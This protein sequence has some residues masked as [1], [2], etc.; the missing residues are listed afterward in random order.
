MLLVV[1]H[2]LM[3]L[4]LVVLGAVLF[5]GRGAFLI[6]GYNTMPKSERAKYDVKR[7]CRGVGKLLFAIAGC[8]VLIALSAVFDSAALYWCGLGLT[9]AVAIGGI[10]YMNTGNR[11]KN[12]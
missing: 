11:Y 8:W 4:L 7:L 5:S 10:V 9:L 1:V 3:I 12:E 6:A 2:G